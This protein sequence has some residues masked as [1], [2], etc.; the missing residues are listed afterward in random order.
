MQWVEESGKTSP[1]FPVPGNYL[2]PSLAPDASRLVFTWDGDIWVYDLK[3]TSMSRLTLGGGY[4][5]P[6]W[7]TDGRYVVFR[8]AQGIFWVD[9]AGRSSPQRLIPTRNPQLPWSFTPKGDRLAFID[10]DPVTG[11]D[12][13]T[14]PVTN[15][16]AGLKAGQPELFLRTP[17]QERS[18]MFSPDGKWIAYM[19]NESGEPQVY[20]D[21]FPRKGSKHRVSVERAGYP[22]WQ[23]NGSALFFLSLVGNR[24]LMIAP[25]S[26]HGG[27]F[28]SEAPQVWSTKISS[29]S[30]TRTYEPGLDARRVVALIPAEDAEVQRERVVFLLNFFDELKRRAPL[31][32]Y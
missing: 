28:I 12:I 29:F 10:I 25:Y 27:S 9:A 23:R 26:A 2:S 24:P 31:N 7:T 13:W 5:N 22:A 18:P 21:S 17:F 3:H 16:A 32:A 11:A 8:A 30:T 14:V 15:S 6:L 19:S 1:V 4:G 20:V